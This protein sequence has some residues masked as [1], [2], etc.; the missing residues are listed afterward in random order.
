[1][2]FVFLRVEAVRGYRPRAKNKK[3]RNRAR[4]YIPA[5]FVVGISCRDWTLRIPFLAKEMRCCTL[6]LRCG[7]ADFIDSLKNRQVKSPAGFIL[8][9]LLLW[10][11]SILYISRKSSSFL[12]TGR[13]SMIASMHPATEKVIAEIS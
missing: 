6:L 1:M 11:L 3:H 9:Q 12:K 4:I 5:L 8:I 13:G 7:S 2:N 10:D